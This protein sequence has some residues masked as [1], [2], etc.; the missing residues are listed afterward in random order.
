M[1]RSQ[2][3]TKIDTAFAANAAPGFIRIIPDATAIPGA[4]SWDAGFP[5][6]TMEPIASGG[7]PP[8]GQDMNGVLNA[9]TAWTRWNASAGGSVSFDATFAGEVGGYPQ[10]ALLWATNGLGFW[11]SVIDN[12]TTN[13]D[14]TPSANWVFI[15]TDQSWAGNPNGN[16][17]G[18]A[19]TAE[20]A[21][22]Q[23]WDSTN[24]IFWYCTATGIAA[25]ATWAPVVNVEP[26]NP[27][28]TGNSY[29]YTVTDNGQ[30]RIR[31]NSGTS[32]TDALPSAGVTNGWKVAIYNNDPTALLTIVAPGG[33]TINNG[34]PGGSLIL[35]PT[36]KTT[37]VVDAAGNFW[38]DV[39]PIPVAFSG[40]AIYVNTSGTY[41][42]G[43]YDLDTSGGP[44]TFTLEAGGVL[45][46]NY[47]INDVA[48]F[49]STNKVTV[50]GNGRNI[51]GAATFP[52]DV[53]WTLTVL[54]LQSNVWK[55]T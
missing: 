8:F 28:V 49:F 52:L 24:F 10:G 51:E 27:S 46:D 41:A 9:I 26:V 33:K 5:P 14:T 16:V 1:Q 43:V 30:F 31:A 25:V 34:A 53:N 7:I 3:P 15:A 36:Q 17:A 55:A 23:C 37:V 11:L 50:N 32:M 6:V 38:L 42:P 13:P 54:S 39:P 47:R 22:T 44:I 4:A 18:Q 19:A 45:G 48:G 40:Q 29:N 20:N 35:Q 21:A 12:N 2:I